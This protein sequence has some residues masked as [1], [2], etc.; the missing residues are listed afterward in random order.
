LTRAEIVDTIGDF[1][2]A[3]WMAIR[4]AD[5]VEIHGANGCLLQQ[6]TAPTPTTATNATAD[7]LASS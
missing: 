3:A 5:A 7:S 1:A 6:F 4:P 2:N